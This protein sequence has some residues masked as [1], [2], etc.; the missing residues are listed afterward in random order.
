MPTRVR[1]C[2]HAFL[3]ANTT[4]IHTHLRAHTRV[5]PQHTPPT[6]TPAHTHTHTHQVVGYVAIA[7]MIHPGD[8]M[9]TL[10][11]NSIK[12]DLLSVSDGAQVCVCVAGGQLDQEQ[13]TLGLGRRTGGTHT[14]AHTHIHTHTHT[15]TH[16]HTP[17]AGP[18][19]SVHRKLGRDGPG[20][21][22]GH[23]HARARAHT[24]THT[25]THTGRRPWL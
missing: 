8:E 13:S 23:T 22:S 2:T 7:L 17:V 24:H 14:R 1:P 18:G 16:A 12:N 11:V 15:R 10:V 21:H 5:P 19:S 3:C 9:M 6:H 25:R 20:R 4:R